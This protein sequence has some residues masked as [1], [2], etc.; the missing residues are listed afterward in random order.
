[1]VL[2]GMQT[3]LVAALVVALLLGLGAC[4]SVVSNAGA[5]MA[6]SISAAMLN[7]D[8]PEIVRD[9]AP[10]FLMMLDGM[11]E[12]SPDNPALLAAASE[13]YAAYGVV[14]VADPERAQKLTARARDYGRRALCATREAGCQIWNQ[15]YET[16]EARLSVFKK[17]DVPA[18]YTLALSEMAYIRTHSGD[19]GALARLPEVR[20]T[21][22]RMQ[23]LD[24]DFRPAK[25]EQYLGVLNT[26][27]PPALG[28]DF[29]AGK[30]HFE[31][32]LSAQGQRDLSIK[33]DYA[34]FYARTLYEREL[35]DQL[36]TEV[37]E[38]DPNQRGFVLTNTLAQE[39]ARALLES[40]DDYF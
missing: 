33:V 10:A 17:E 31:K 9:G 29:D 38:A 15:P 27:R 20:I 36:L 11:V 4:S 25:T 16:Y 6:S 2:K 22:E 24:P 30:A 18:L 34:K 23:A 12:N 37:L 5:G 32:A 8:D 35:H 1:M 14:F 13:L 21:L 26:I 28:G 7:Q 40:A 3:A 39:E 19:W